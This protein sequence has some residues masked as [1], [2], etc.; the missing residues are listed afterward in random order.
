MSPRWPRAARCR[1]AQ[2]RRPP[3]RDDQ[4]QGRQPARQ[5]TETACA[6]GLP[7]AG[8]VLGLAR[9]EEVAL[10]LAELVGVVG[11][12]FAR[13]RQVARRDT[14]RLG[15]APARPTRA[16]RRQAAVDEQS[17]R[18]VSIQP[19]SR[20]Q[21]RI[22]ASWATTTVR[23]SS[24]TRRAS[25]RMP[26]T[27]S[28]AARV[29]GATARSARSTRRRVGSAPSPT[30][31]RLRKIERAIARSASGRLLQGALGGLCDRAAHAA[32]LVVAA[33]GEHQ[34]SAA[35]PRLKQ[36]VREQRQRARL[37]SQ[38]LRA[39]FR[40][41]PAAAGD[42]VSR[43]RQLDS[44]PKVGRAHRADQHLVSDDRRRQLRVGGHATVEV[45]AQR[46]DHDDGACGVAP[47]APSARRRS[48]DARPRRGTA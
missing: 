23:S 2:A 19:R 1:A 16:R 36:S 37:V 8:C 11:R 39:S 22:S 40:L 3:R 30:S 10:E 21:W 43:G 33:D 32:G 24:V 35:L 47:R 27:R 6:A 9:G 38:D 7:A 17:A 42:R 28:T 26:S 12:P 48:S 13:P 14:A 18:S 46:E 29:C 25:T 4:G 41:G 44:P 34:P 31:V 45:R 5:G 20:G 15:R